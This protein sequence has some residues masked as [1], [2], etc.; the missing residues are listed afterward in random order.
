MAQ[1]DLLLASQHFGPR[2]KQSPEQKLMIAVLQ[3]ALDCLEK[4]RSAT[5]SH[6]CRL[7][8]ETR[9]WFLADE[10]AWPYSFECICL[11]LDLDASAVRRRLGV[12]PEPQP[13]AQMRAA[14]LRTR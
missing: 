9:Q 14:G 10:P 3:D 6:E 2:G 7:L 12:V 4:Y 5:K 8:H 13:V 1:P 11:T